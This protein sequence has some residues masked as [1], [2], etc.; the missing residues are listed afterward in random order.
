MPRA[1]LLLA[2]LLLA[3]GAQPASGGTDDVR[4]EWELAEGTL[5]GAD[6][7]LPPG[8]GATLLLEDVEAS[9]TSFCNHYGGTYRVD[10][11]AI[12]FE[13][14]GGT[15]MACA[16]DVMAAE[17]AYLRALGSV[18]TVA[19][20]G[21]ILLLTG[22]DVRLR[23]VPVVP[24]PDSPLEGTEWVLDTVVEGEVAGTTLGEPVLRVA[25]DGTASASTGC[26][27][28]TGRWL[29][30]DGALVIDDF[31]V[32]GGPCGLDLVRQDEIVS[33]VLDSAPRAEIQ[34]DRL[35]LTAADGRGLV[36]RA[37]S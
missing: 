28:I 29:L 31:L 27:S 32:T 17:S 34:E 13:N 22:D 1:A 16:P 7:L 14:L 24:V 3:A 2:V 10:G 23:F 20:E 4:G 11:D 9:G 19:V 37:A 33:A 12:A 36:Y 26:R 18:R 35:T 8:S 21:N 30:D 15:E 6:L 5:D 25:A